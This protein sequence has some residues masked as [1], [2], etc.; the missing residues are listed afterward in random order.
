MAL[1]LYFLIRAFAIDAA[2]LVLPEPLTLPYRYRP[3]PFDCM[4]R[5]CST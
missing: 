1:M 5:Y 4:T 2:S 3:L